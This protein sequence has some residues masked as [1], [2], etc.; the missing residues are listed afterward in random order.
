MEKPD[1][2]DSV[3]RQLCGR[4]AFDLQLKACGLKSRPCRAVKQQP[5][6]SWS[7]PLAWWVAVADLSEVWEKP[8]LNHAAGGGIHH[9]SHCE[10]QSGAWAL[11]PINCLKNLAFLDFKNDNGQGI[12]QNT[13]S[14]FKVFNFDQHCSTLAVDGCLYLQ[15]ECSLTQN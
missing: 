12:I 1:L 13:P 14:L 10:M 6:A 3:T 8:G 7:H 5:W 9:D 15:W 4:L 11:A 2:N